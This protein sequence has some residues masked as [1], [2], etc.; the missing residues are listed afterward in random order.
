ML[1]D[2]IEAELA[3]EPFVP[4]RLH[5]R[6]GKTFDIPFRDVARVL[7]FGLLVF[8]G[9]KRG[10]RQAAGYDRFA[11]DNIIRIEQRRTR[12]GQRRRKAS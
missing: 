8:V 2:Q 5:L 9:L 12:N 3:R 10:T 4:L 7:P 6:D 1:R 11:F